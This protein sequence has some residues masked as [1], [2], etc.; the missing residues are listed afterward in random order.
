MPKVY[1]LVDCNNFFVSCERV[2]N[3]SLHN[4]PVVVLSNN[5]GCV[6]ARSNEAKA[7]GIKMGSPAFKNKALLEQHGVRIYSSNYSL[8][9]DMSGR[10][11]NSLA[12]MAADI[13]IYSIDEAFLLLSTSHQQLTPFARNIRNTVLKWTGMPVSIGIGSTKT[14]A[15]IANRFVKKSPEYD[16]VLDLTCKGLLHEYLKQ[17][18]IEDVWGIGRRYAPLLKSYGIRNALDF[19]RQSRDWVKSTM[20]VTGL[21]TLLEIQGRPCFTLKT[22]PENNKTIISSR[23]FGKGVESLDELREAVAGYTVRAAEKL[24]RQGLVCSNIM[25]FIH[26]SRFKKGHPQYDNSRMTRMPCPADYTPTLIKYALKV[27][28]EIYQEGYVYKKAGVMLAGMENKKQRQ[29][30]FFMPSRASEEKEKKITDVME[31][32]NKRWGRDT[33]RPAAGGTSREWAMQR[34]LLSPRYTTCWN[35]LPVAYGEVKSRTH[36]EKI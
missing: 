19:S 36:G 17:T 31:R 1:A 3:P 22:M 25:V 26:T 29:L 28:E 34:R 35:E 12:A 33:I 30:T 11:M 21:Q 10:V 6:I 4:M 27:L 24:R 14:L 32:I 15:K 20:T 18:D 7:L 5:D 16:G 23:S 8:Y 13:E 9:G 2:F